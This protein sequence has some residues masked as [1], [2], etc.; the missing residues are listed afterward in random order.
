MKKEEVA[1][2]GVIC[3]TGLGSVALIMGHNG[4]LMLALGSIISGIVGLVFG[5]KLGKKAE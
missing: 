4:Q 2:V 3:V 5:V 1:V